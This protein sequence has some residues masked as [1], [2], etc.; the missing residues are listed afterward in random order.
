VNDQVPITVAR[1]IVL[2]GYKIW[3]EGSLQENGI[4][5]LQLFDSI[6]QKEFRRF[7]DLGVIDKEGYI[8]KLYPLPRII[9]RPWVAC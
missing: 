8:T 3:S 9:I 6:S 2:R 1:R 4:R 5:Y 7:V